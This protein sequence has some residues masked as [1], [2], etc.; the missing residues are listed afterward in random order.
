MKP[1]IA[2]QQVD[3]S[4]GEKNVIKKVNLTIEEGELFVLV[5]PSGSG[6]TTLLKMMNRLISPSVGQVLFHGKDL[7]KENIRQVRFKMGYVLQQIALFPN[8]TVAENIELIPEMMG[9]KKEKR[10]KRAY[11]LLEEVGLPPKEYAKRK[12]KELSGGEQQRIGILRGLAASPEILLMDEPFSALDPLSRSSLQDLVIKINRERKTTIVFVTHD[13]SEALKVATRIGVLNHGE[14]VQVDTPE[15]LLQNPQTEF[16]KEFF[17]TTVEKIPLL[18]QPIISF[19][20]NQTQLLAPKK[21][22]PEVM[23]YFIF[24]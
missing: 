20:N 1:I 14:V 17:K 13:M 11:E 12:P 19:L 16:V 22:Q 2:F 23:D 6:K 21:G 3:K 5:G 7:A 8:L 10:Q 18:Q 24:K 9:W 15:E 4:F